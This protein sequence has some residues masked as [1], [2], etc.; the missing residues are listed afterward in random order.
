M[1]TSVSQR[2]RRAVAAALLVGQSG[3]IGMRAVRDPVRYVNQDRPPRVWAVLD[4]GSTVAVEAPAVHRD[5]L[6]G[7]DA[8]RA[9]VVL[10]MHRVRQ[11]NGRFLSAT[12]TAALIAGLSV[13]LGATVLLLEGPGENGRFDPGEDRIAVDVS[14]LTVRR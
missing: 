3:C 14:H 4:D 9:P 1:P 5:T 12:R 8:A 10:P 11:L 7:L 13:A 2:A 6:I